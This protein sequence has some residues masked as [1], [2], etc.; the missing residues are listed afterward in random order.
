[1]A[2]GSFNDGFRDAL[3][4]D[5]YASPLSEG[6]FIQKQIN[7]EDMLRTGTIAAMAD[8]ETQVKINED[9]Y[10]RYAD[11]P[12]ETTI[13]ASV[14][15][16][17][18]LWDKIVGSTPDASEE[19]RIKMD[20]L[21]AAM[22]FTSQGRTFMHGGAEMLRSKP[23]PDREH[24]VD[25]NSYDSGDST[26]QIVWSKTEKYSDVVE[27]YKGL[28]DMRLSHEAFRM[29]TMEEIQNGITFIKED[30]PY[31]MGFKLEEQNGEDNWEEIMVFY[32]SNREEKT[33]EVDELNSDWKVVVDGE[34]AGNEVIAD[35]EVE[36]NDG[37]ITIP[38]ISAVVIYR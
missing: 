20:K 3:K 10:H 27:Y 23:D 5:N 1:K 11:D 16:G 38:A 37:E 26:N 22:V 24:G 17:Y 14:H 32:N 6:G 2:V 19:E 28:I 13:Y 36:I 18:T 9:T 35:T 25:H 31:F 29:E 30:I 33:V 8:F 34:K 21:A 4:Q 12:E 15:D 7:K